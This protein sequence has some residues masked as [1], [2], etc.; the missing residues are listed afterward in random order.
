[1]TILVTGTA[2]FVGF[3]LAKL[4]LEEGFEVAGV[5]AVTEYYDVTLKRDRLKELAKYDGFT[6][7]EHYLEAVTGSLVPGPNCAL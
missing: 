7:Y 6:P 3:H 4:L 2:G 1:M 5:D